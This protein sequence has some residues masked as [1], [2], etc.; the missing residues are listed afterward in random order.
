MIQ[1][2]IKQVYIT[3][4]RKDRILL[5]DEEIEIKELSKEDV[6]KLQKEA[7]EIAQRYEHAASTIN[8]VRTCN[9]WGDNP[10]P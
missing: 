7:R 6:N 10:V 8:F 1:Q 9:T 3:N 2:S 4:S 5:V